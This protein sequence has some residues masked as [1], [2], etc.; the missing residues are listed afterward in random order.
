MFTAFNAIRQRPATGRAG[1]RAWS[2][3]CG[4]LRPQ[5]IAAGQ[6]CLALAYH[7]EDP[8]PPGRTRS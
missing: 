2:M 7:L 6:P 8:A 3:D 5:A 4:A 1:V